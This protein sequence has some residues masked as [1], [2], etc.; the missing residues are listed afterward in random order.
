MKTY[1]TYDYENELHSVVCE[2]AAVYGLSQPLDFGIKSFL[3]NKMLVVSAIRKGFPFSLFERIQ[4]SLPF[5]EAD[6][7]SFLDISTKTLQRYKQAK[8]HLFKASHT[9]KIIAIT[10]VTEMGLEVFGDI[11]KFKLWLETPSY[12]LGGYAP[13]ELLKDAY[14]KELVMAELVRISHG[15]LA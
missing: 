12:A 11:H 10:E 9:E 13:F 2:E 3:A 15:I 6:W 7:A 4:Q 5:S 14:G 1:P 8:Q